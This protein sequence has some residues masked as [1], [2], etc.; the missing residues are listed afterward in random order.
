[1]NPFFGPD[2]RRAI[3]PEIRGAIEEATGCT[4]VCGFA[5]MLD[6]GDAAVGGERISGFGETHD[7]REWLL[8]LSSKKGMTWRTEPIPADSRS[9]VAFVLNVGLGNGSPLPQPSGRW[10]LWVNDRFALS[11]RV[12]N[13]SQ[14]WTGDDCSFAF[15]ANRL[16]SAE[17]YGSLT[18]SSL[19]RDEGFAAFGPALLTVPTSWLE[20]GRPATLRVQSVSEVP[21]TRWLQIAPS[22]HLLQTTDIWRAV[23][24]LIKEHPQVDGYKL[25][26]GDIHT[27]SGQVMDECENK[28]CG[29]GTRV[30]NYEYA[31]GAGGLDFYA[32]TDHEWQIDPAKIDEYMDLAD[33]YN[34]DDRF[35]CVPGFEYTNLLYG[36]RNVYFRETGGTVFNTN[37]EWGRP[38]LDPARCNTPH[39]LWEAMER[40]GVPFITV[41]HHPSATSHPLN[42]DVYNPR[43]D[44]LY[45]VYSSWGSSEYYGDFPRGVSDRFRTG[46][47]RNAFRRGQRYGI[48]AS[49]DGHDGHP[50][51]AQSPLVKHHHIFHF[52]GSGRAVVL[53]DELTRAAVFDALHDRRCYATTGVPIVLDV[54]TNGALMGTELPSLPSGTVPQ[55][56]IT[57]RGTNGLDHI[58]I[59]KNG[60][61]ADTLPCH[62]AFAF[63]AEW[64]DT[65]Y[66][67]AS[68]YYVRIVQK[69][70]E[71]AWSS[72][73]WIG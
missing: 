67:E 21:S 50:G 62:G 49:S 9:R 8:N 56:K 54:R 69:D 58:R 46:D 60:E 66:S 51:N 37:T 13:H 64:E 42:L 32:L 11:I 35:V 38:T 5:E 70:R 7:R 16:E 65:N 22:A 52:C 68:S 47:L 1:M 53:A 61:V 48:I 15:A 45:E 3:V 41:P 43:F 40:T 36:H 57:C 63:D 39:D 17:P 19:V 33:H 18:L 30:E 71:S 2:K 25:F 44:R 28:G 23:D 29:M 10:D 14:R 55:V 4:P 12:V 34:Q 27:H 6:A 72:P 31:K 59:V 73:V 20:G 24:L 26:F